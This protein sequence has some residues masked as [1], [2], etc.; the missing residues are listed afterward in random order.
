MRLRALMRTGFRLA[1]VSGLASLLAALAGEAAWVDWTLSLLFLAGL[2][3]MAIAAGFSALAPA[4]DDEEHR[5]VAFEIDDAGFKIWFGDHAREN[6]RRYLEARDH[7]ASHRAYGAWP[8]TTLRWR[9][10]AGVSHRPAWADPGVSLREAE[11]GWEDLA[12]TLGAPWPPMTWKPPEKRLVTP[13]SQSWR[14]A[15]VDFPERPAYSNYD[16]RGV[17]QPP[18]PIHFRTLDPP[19]DPDLG[20]RVGH[21]VLETH[22][23][24]HD[25]CPV[26]DTWRW[27]TGR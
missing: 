11:Q 18:F 1:A 27:D 23:D 26:C 10:P 16:R 21:A 8:D 15:G 9:Y 12:R 5:Q 25:G 3:D 2:T 17:P 7:G 13:L 6:H 22:S 4:R 20:V 19:P 14:D 24:P